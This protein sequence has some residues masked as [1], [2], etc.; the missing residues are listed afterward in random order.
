MTRI[1]SFGQQGVLLQATLRNQEQLFR[2]QKQ[3]TTGKKASQFRE[4]GSRVQ[5]ALNAR[6]SREAVAT[7]RST[8]QQVR[9]TVDAYDVQ[10]GAVADAARSL[11]QAVVTA[12]G[13]EDATGLMA[14]LD[15]AFTIA[16][17]ALN[18]RING[19]FI[20]GGAR[21]D[22]PPVTVSTLSDLQALALSSDAFGN[23]QTIRSAF[24]AE[25]TDIKFGQ[26]ANGVASEIFASFKRIAD[27]DA[28]PS[29]P[30]SGK[31]TAAQRAF[32]ETEIGNIES[33]VQQIQSAQVKNGL[34]SNRLDVADAQHESTQ[35][36]LESLVSDIEDVNLAEAVSRLNQDQV[37]LQASFEAL[38]TLGQLS[39]L[40]FL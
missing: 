9:Q 3:I 5:E 37:A 21:T 18:T 38:R 23:D 14:S 26:L 31:L 24:I 15:Q 10:I 2:A 12:V 33:A 17:S 35:V 1:S 19:N 36:F 34:A 39:L 29:G 4:L 6:Q 8:I 11:Q 7:F 22:Q 16:V 32:L 25:G 27:F 28:G 13:Q 20:F 40:N 30:L